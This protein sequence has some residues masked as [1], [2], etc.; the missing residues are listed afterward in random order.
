MAYKPRTHQIS[1]VPT[2][3]LH[4]WC[5]CQLTQSNFYI[6]KYFWIFLGSHTTQSK[7]LRKHLQ[8]SL[9]SSK[10]LLQTFSPCHLW[11]LAA[12]FTADLGLYRGISHYLLILMLCTMYFSVIFT[13]RLVSHWQTELGGG[14]ACSRLTQW[15]LTCIWGCW[16]GSDIFLP[17]LLLLTLW[18]T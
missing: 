8:N 7:V 6:L 3:S 10:S 12:I 15:G 16:T 4:E 13:L 11:L 14:S 17:V 9:F 5:W 2:L 18:P 1:T